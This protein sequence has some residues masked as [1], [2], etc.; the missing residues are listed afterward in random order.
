M[1]AFKIFTPLLVA[2]LAWSPLQAKEAAP[3][4]VAGT[5]TVSAAEAKK[6]FDAGAVF[7]DVRGEAD[8]E[9]GRIPGAKHIAVKGKLSEEALLA[10]VKKDQTV[11]MYCN[12]QKCGLSAEACGK[13]VS[14]GF[15]NVKYFRDGFPGWQKA[16][17]PVE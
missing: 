8:Y 1:R 10:A 9:A 14:W 17:H 3:M 4:S 6:L 5:T 16:G 15:K 11:V 2:L 13:A 7:V 12:G